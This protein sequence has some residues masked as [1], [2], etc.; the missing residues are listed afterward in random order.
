M[1]P[2]KEICLAKILPMSSLKI[3]FLAS[4]YPDKT[5]PLSGNFIQKHAMA[6]SKFCSVT[7]IYVSA[8]DQKEKFLLED[9]RI[10]NLSEIRV[11][12]KKSMSGLRFWRIL[13]TYYMKMKAYKM[14]FVHLMLKNWMPD[15]VHVNVFFPAGLFAKKLKRKYGLHYIITEHWTKFLPSS[16]EKF[17]F[18]ERL[19]LRYIFSGADIVCPVSE[20]LKN[21]MMRMGLKNKYVVVPNVVDPLTFFPSIENQFSQ[22]VRFLHIS[23]LEDKHKNISGILRTF[24]NLSLQE[25]PFS[26]TIVGDRNLD[27]AID[28]AYDLDIPENVIRFEGPK[29][30]PEIAEIMRKHDVFVMFSHYENLP[31]VISE[32][33]MT[34]LPVIAS[35][36]GGIP[37]MINNSNGVLVAAEDEN[38]FLQ[39]LNFMA[40]HY[41][42]YDKKRIVN[43]ANLLYGTTAVGKNFLNI[44]LGIL[45]RNND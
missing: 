17:S 27:K 31:C 32:A 18:Q 30:E 11:Y 23:H 16:S 45:N 42:E 9:I 39:E 3:L 38:A 6:V 4:W 19:T 7:V 28:L 5:K 24:K 33:L 44:Y 1:L 36:V 43:D 8:F 20:N 12:Y 34:G 26:L 41:K 21:E 15:F 40:L 25:I 14:A 29:T 2:L 22:P 35:S 37:E 10:N 13:K